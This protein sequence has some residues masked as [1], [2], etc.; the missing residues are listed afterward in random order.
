MSTLKVLKSAVPPP[1]ETGTGTPKPEN[2][3]RI[4]GKVSITAA[5]NIHR[6]NLPFCSA[7][8]W[9]RSASPAS[10]SAT[11]AATGA[12]PSNKPI[13]SLIICIIEDQRCWAN[14]G[15]APPPAPR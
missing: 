11:S 7:D 9:F 1:A 5:Q 12:K 6:P 13:P 14:E 10:T 15:T 8:P 2:Q 3:L 4:C